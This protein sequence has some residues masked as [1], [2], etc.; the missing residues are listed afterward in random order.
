MKTFNGVLGKISVS[1]II[2]FVFTYGI[3]RGANEMI[4]AAVVKLCA[5]VLYH[6]PGNWTP[7]VVLTTGVKYQFLPF[8]SVIY[9]TPELMRRDERKKIMLCGASNQTLKVPRS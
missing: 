7:T 9:N 5:P 6:N 2:V 4:N 1:F 8:Y 3:H